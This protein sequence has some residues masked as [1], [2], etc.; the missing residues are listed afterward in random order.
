[1]PGQ[2]ELLMLIGEAVLRKMQGG[3]QANGPGRQD[4]SARDYMASRTAGGA[5]E[6][7]SYAPAFFNRG[8]PFDD[9][10]EVPGQVSLNP[11]LNHY[12]WQSAMADLEAK[13]AMQAG[14]HYPG[15][16]VDYGQGM[17]GQ[18]PYGVPAAV[19]NPNPV[20]RKSGR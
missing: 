8:N 5:N 18:V 6:D 7:A 9:E 12:I 10:T 19:R 20:Y 11:M 16:T 14:E 17:T 15:M 2:S 13:A 3:G 1:M 4:N